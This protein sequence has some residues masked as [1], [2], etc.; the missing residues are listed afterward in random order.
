MLLAGD[1]APPFNLPDATGERYILRDQVGFPQLLL[2][3]ENESRVENARLLQALQ[4]AQPDFTRIGARIVSVSPAN[5]EQR[6]KFAREHG[7]GFR[8]LCDPLHEVASMFEL[9]SGF[10]KNPNPEYPATAFLLDA[11]LMII[12]VLPFSE[13]HI[14]AILETIKLCCPQK[15]PYVV[16]DVYTPPVLLIPDVLDPATCQDLIDIWE[17]EGNQVSHFMKSDGDK[18]YGVVDARMKIRRD[19]FI[20]DESVKQRINGFFQ[21]RVYPEIVKCFN[22]VVDEYEHFKIACYDSST[23]GYFRQHRDNTSGGTAHRKWA[24]SLNLNTEFEGGYLRFPE[25]GPQLYRPPMGSAVV[26]SCSLMHEATDVTAGRRFCLLS[27]FYGEQ[28]S[29]DREQYLKKYG[30]ANYIPKEVYES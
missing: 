15:E 29:R 7:I 14:P 12:G 24:L 28:E 19:H 9:Y 10:P 11:N 26:F 8:L 6:T 17:N 20:R 21:R 30:A 18:T 1:H 23:G 25:Y 22:Y 13:E 3:H 5:A 27:F 16:T 4:K 2:F